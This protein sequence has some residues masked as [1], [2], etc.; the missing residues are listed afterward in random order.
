MKGLGC[1]NVMVVTDPGVVKAGIGDKV[2]TSLETAGLKAVV[3]DQV[4]ADPPASLVL[5]ACA[6]AAKV[7]KNTLCCVACGLHV[8][9]SF[10]LR[11]S[12]DGAECTG[13]SRWRVGSWR[14]FSNGRG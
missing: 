3:F 1:K 14:R 13:R 10:A 9:G 5:Q 4:V 6:Y 11:V 7:K 12:V 2:K 8:E